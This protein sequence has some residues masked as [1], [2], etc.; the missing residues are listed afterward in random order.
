MKT[1]DEQIKCVEREIAMRKR[2]YQKRVL[3][4]KMSKQTAD[5]ELECMA[6]VLE[7]LQKQKQPTLI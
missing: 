7:T 5:H 2:V 4:E 6:A 3:E 1:L